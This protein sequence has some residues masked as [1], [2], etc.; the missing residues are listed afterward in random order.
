M[1]SQGPRIVSLVLALL[2]AAIILHIAMPP[3]TL[4]Q[5]AASFGFN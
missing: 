1:K 5:A 3:G 4:S 2:A